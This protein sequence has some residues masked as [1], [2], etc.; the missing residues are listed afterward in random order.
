MLK[1]ALHVEPENKDE[2]K[3]DSEMLFEEEEEKY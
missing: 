3:D 2:T 1:E